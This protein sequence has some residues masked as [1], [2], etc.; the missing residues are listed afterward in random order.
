MHLVREIL[1]ER[2]RPL[3]QHKH[4][5]VDALRRFT[6]QVTYQPTTEETERLARRVHLDAG[7]RGLVA[8][9]PGGAEWLLVRRLAERLLTEPDLR[10]ELI[11]FECLDERHY[12][13]GALST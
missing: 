2:L 7:Q 8:V 10:G 13:F 1:E 6:A 11:G 12:L 4:V 3:R 9:L 5:G